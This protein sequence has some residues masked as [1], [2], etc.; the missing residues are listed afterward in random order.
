MKR[1]HSISI[2]LFLLLSSISL[3]QAPRS[4][5]NDS[6]EFIKELTLLFESINLEKNKEASLESLNRFYNLWSAERFTPAQKQLVYNTSNLMLQKRVRAYPGFNKFIQALALFKE[7][8]HPENSFNSWLEGMYQ[9]LDSR[10]NS[11]L[12]LKLLDFSSWLL[13]E[14]ILHQSGIYA[15]YCDGGY[16]FNYDSV[17]YVDLPEFDLT[18]RT[19]NDSTT[20]RNTTGKYYPETNLWL[21]ENGKLSWIRAG[22][23][24]NET[25]AVLNDYKF[26]LNSLKFEI[27]S[28]V[29][30]NKKYFPDAL[31]G[32]LQE[33]VSTNK[34][35]P[36]KVSYPQFESYS[37]NLYIADIY[38]DID[39]EG[40]FAMKGARVYGTGDKYH[41]ASFSFKKEYLN[42]N[43]YYDLLIARSKSFVINNDIISSARAAITIYHQ[44]DS[45]FHSGLLF[46]YIHK[47]REVS[48]LRLEKGIVQSP[49]FDT[50]HDVEIDCEAVYWNMGE[51]RI[52]FRAIKGLGKISNVVISSKN[53][54]SEQHF[55]YL[56]G[57]DFK[58]PLFR[59]RDY[60]RKYNTEEFFIYEMARNLKL[61]EAQI[62]ALVIYLAQQGF[63][64]YDIDNKK[65]YIT[66]KLHHFCDSKNGTSDYDVITFSSEVEN[67]NNATLNLDNFDLKIRGVP[68]VSISDSQNVFIYPSKEE[69][70]L[71][72]N[73]DF[74]FSGKVTAGLFEFYATDCYFEYDTFKLNLPNIEHM[75]FKVKSFERDPSGY[76]SFVDVNTVISN[77][78]GSLL[79]DHPTNK[80]G[81]ADYPEYPTFNTQSNS[82]V[83]YDHDSANREAYNRE[84]FFYYLNPFT[85]ESMEDFS[86]ENLTFSGHLN[87]GGIF[88]E[89]T[90]PLSVQ[91]DYSLGFTTLA[92]D[93]G[94][95]IY[96]GKGNYSSQILLSNNGLRGKGDLQYLSST[97]SSEDIIFFL[98]SVNSN[99]QSFEL[100]K[101]TS[102]D[103]SYP[104]VRATN[105]YQHWTPYSDSM[106]INSK[107]SVMLMYDGLATLD[108]NLLLTPKNLTGKGRMKFFDA[109]MSADIFDYSDH[110][111]TA[112]TTDFHIKSVEGAGLAL[113]T[114]KYNATMD[115]DELTG[116]FKTTNDNAVIEFPLNRFMCTMDEFDWYIKRNELV[117]RGY[118]DI[119]VPGLNKMPLKEIIDVDLTGSE[120]TSLHPLQDSLAF[121]TLN[122][123]FNLDS[124]LLVA[125]DVKIIRVADAAIFPGDGRVEIGENARVSPLTDA[126]IIADT[127]NK[128]H[129]ISNAVV[130]IQSRYSYTAN[131][132]YTFYNS[133][134]QPQIIQ[135]DD[136]KVDTA[137][138]TYALGNIGVE[139]EFLLGPQFGFRGVATLNA[140]NPLLNFD[141]AYM[142][143]QDCDLDYS[144]WVKFNKRLNPNQLHLPVAPR[145]EEFAQKNLYAAFF[146]SNENNRVYPAF[147]SR[148]EY[149]SDTLMLSVDGF[150][151]ARDENKELLIA[152]AQEINIEDGKTPEGN[153]M[154]LNTTN[155]EVKARGEIRF[156]ARLGQVSMRSFG[157]INHFIIP[158]S[159]GMKLFMIMDF[160]FADEAL[161]YMFQQLDL[162]NTKGINMALPQVRTAF[163]ELLGQEEGNKIIKDLNL[164]G[165]I[166]KTPEALMKSI[167]F[168]DVEMYY[169][170]NSR[171][172]Q[173]VGPIGI[174]SILGEQVNKYYT[175]YL[176]LV[177]RRSGDVLNL[178]LEIDRRHWYF[179]SYSHNVMQS[180]SSRTDFNK[181]LREIKDDK[182]KDVQEKDRVAYRYIISTTQKKNRF[183]RDMRKGGSLEEE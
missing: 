19:K 94:F 56:Q 138:R 1:A 6:I 24:G 90:A 163:I 106:S 95:P 165:T 153:F 171:S 149:Y 58:H 145:P 101:V 88:P 183:L 31:L 47:N 132:T 52:N 62:E 48:M 129:V 18:C 179:F 167:V 85:I 130:S 14:N 92:P 27:D 15:W 161:K 80:N 72:K 176:Q 39:F 136:I 23:G 154:G 67:T 20:I 126:T 45:I 43:D 41:D 51:P 150:I 180:I 82:Y 50:F 2:S 60:S 84:R 114:T 142:P 162:A 143:I 17:L 134:G 97:A 5:S 68:V 157:N 81:L 100:T 170:K 87:S 77:I 12:F 156:G 26:F 158:D 104:P 10:R 108:G 66:D 78:S 166:R 160:H 125:E 147:L 42:K 118:L 63:L 116:N 76:H 119:D 107:D 172:F 75:K 178:Y 131:G 25:Y 16:R 53:F 120:L 124:S 79:I 102:F 4:F 46:K 113:S 151:K 174:G 128:Q 109:V 99:S 141:G 3:A 35:N 11:R 112:D 93:Q 177:K 121:F 57:I 182:R 86:T 152:S 173:S 83:Y 9:S 89:I 30:V 159:T 64:Y 49:Y 98:D 55:D 155:C 137:Y 8:S 29:F 37:H 144:K 175:G 105:V 140:H 59:I 38:K 111:F 7:K 32:R 54:Y 110:Y 33:K 70:I 122:A 36:K 181:I 74:L 146:H 34:I 65:A 135:F 133:A 91:P 71:R 115:F 69:V 103:V 44:E 139:Q 148:K 164:Y 117:F 123:S 61:P 40:G 22:L 21:G 13:N 96:N 169:D 168:G 73:L 127:A 28:V